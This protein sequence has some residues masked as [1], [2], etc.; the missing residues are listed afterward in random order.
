VNSQVV[1]SLR[2]AAAIFGLVCLAQLLRLITRAE[3]IVA[4]NHVPLWP[5][6]V[7]VVISGAMSF[8]LWKLSGRTN[9]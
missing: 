2:V 5:S 7:A 9:R 3:I 8:W 4:G 6:A 1:L